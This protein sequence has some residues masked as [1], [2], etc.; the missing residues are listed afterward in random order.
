MMNELS[1]YQISEEFYELAKTALHDK[2]DIDALDREACFTNYNS[3]L[4]KLSVKEKDLLDLKL[5]DKI[6]QQMFDQKNKEI[7]ARKIKIKFE[8]SKLDA[9]T[10][11]SYRNAVRTVELLK[12]PLSYWK[13]KGY[14]ERWILQKIIWSNCVV[15]D[16][17]V[18]SYKETKLFKILKSANISN[19]RA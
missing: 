13:S 4:S 16:K 14:E 18:L 10:S 17:K 9:N 5:E 15:M 1:K 8:L 12:N 3:E 6:S 19:G 2:T 7:S 11:K